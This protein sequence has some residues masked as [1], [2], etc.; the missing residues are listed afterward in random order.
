[1]DQSQLSDI[2]ILEGS[3]SLS[4]ILCN[5]GIVFG[6][7]NATKFECTIYGLPDVANQRIRVFQT[8]VVDTELLTENS[9]EI[10]TEDGF[11]LMVLSESPKFIFSGVVDSC[12]QDSLRQYRDVVAYTSLYF[13]R[14]AN[15]ATAWNAWRLS[16]LTT[17][18]IGDVL[19]FLVDTLYQ[20]IYA[21]VTNPPSRANFCVCDECALSSLPLYNHSAYIGFT[22]DSKK[23]GDMLSEALRLLC[24]CG[25]IIPDSNGNQIFRLVRL[26]PN[27]KDT[28]TIGYP[29]R[30][31]VLSTTFEG[32]STAQVTGVSISDS[33]G[34]L[35]YYNMSG[36]HTNMYHISSLLLSGF[37]R[38]DITSVCS[39]IL[40]ELRTLSFTPCSIKMIVSD[41]SLNLGDV[42][43]V[44][45]ND[46]TTITTF[47]LS[48]EMSGTML[49][50]Q[51]LSSRADE[52]LDDVIEDS[53]EFGT[54][55]A[56]S[57]TQ[58]CLAYNTDETD[59]VP[60][61]ENGNEVAESAWSDT[62]PT[63]PTD[64]TVDLY[65]WTRVA[66]KLPNGIIVYSSPLYA[67]GLSDL[68]HFTVTTS[69]QI[70]QTVDD[71]L[72]EVAKTT[73]DTFGGVIS[74]QVSQIDV[75]TDNIALKVSKDSVISEI[76]QSAEAVTISAEKVNLAGAVTIS[77]LASDVKGEM[78]TD[79]T[80]R[81]QYYFSTSA[82]YLWGGSWW[83][84]SMGTSMP[85]WD[86]TKYVWIRMVTTRTFEDSTSSTDYTTARYDSALT[87]ALQVAASAQTLAGAKRRVFTTTPTPPY[88]AGD[89]W[90]QGEHGDIK[91]CLTSRASG[92]YN[93][94]DWGL[95]S[96]YTDDTT[97]NTALSVANGA[98][99]E[100]SPVYYRS[101]TNT[102]PTLTSSTTIGTSTDTDNVWTY[103]I[104]KPKH[105]CYFYQAERYVYRDSTVGVSTVRSMDSLTASSQWCRENYS[106]YIDGANIYTG[107][108]TS[109]QIYVEE[110]SALNAT[111]GG[112]DIDESDIKTHNV[113][114]TSNA[115]NS[116]GLSSSTFTRTIGGT[117]RSNLKL[118]LGSK[119]G[120]AIDGTVYASD[121]NF[122]GTVN[123]NS[124]SIAGWDI[125]SSRRIE[126]DS[127]SYSGSTYVSGYRTGMQNILGVVHPA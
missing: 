104:P 61:D 26:N 6:E 100:S 13:Y 77:S 73:S 51:T 63:Y 96:K 33:T 67:G 43:S 34:T 7:C 92:S 76:N 127:T 31:E 40:T 23:F 84:D 29:G 122:S 14:D 124:G 70:S 30:Y 83:D 59:D 15:I 86:A 11:N 98:I 42:L 22:L 114:I 17:P 68:N 75:N 24:V 94:N 107:T 89:L 27:Y 8:G 78:V 69:S 87:D 103:C 90:A 74:E 53:V 44:S 88:D 16:L 12:I 56:T 82:S 79:V 113:A 38:A 119:F 120:V 9:V 112:F 58:Y 64:S 85:T 37:T 36:G 106:T 45:R 4:S 18:T 1:M 102:T 35:G 3:L 125:L 20:Y 71:I 52:Y 60:L 126:Y 5:S 118:A 48:N 121:G 72:L 109:E 80:T 66:T 2:R 91:T 115:D 99:S 19:T 97:A 110:L 55:T 10:L 39:T 65:Y 50:E 25:T 111:I 95:A 49:A 116:V 54:T 93:A 32:Y 28:K 117:S 46:G 57:W 105:G 108:V 62:I 47:L 21:N 101:S 81:Q 123:A 41:V